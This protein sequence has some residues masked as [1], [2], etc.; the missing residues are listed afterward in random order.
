MT[1]NI[2]SNCNKNIK[3]KQMKSKNYESSYVSIILYYNT[4]EKIKKTF[5]KVVTY[6]VNKMNDFH[7]R[8][9]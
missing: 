4:G 1:T 8:T 6:V 2:V 9:I 3:K 5:T 7:I